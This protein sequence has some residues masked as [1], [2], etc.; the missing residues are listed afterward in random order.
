MEAGLTEATSGGGRSPAGLYFTQLFG[1]SLDID[2][3]APYP[4]SHL[5]DGILIDSIGH[6][7]LNWF[8]CIGA[9][10]SRGNRNHVRH[11]QI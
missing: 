8:I 11:E 10:N 1:P 6:C 5:D 7:N 4:C 3:T 2:T 9:E